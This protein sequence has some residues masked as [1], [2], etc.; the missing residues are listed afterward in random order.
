[1]REAF[2]Q[3]GKAVIRAR[4]WEND[5]RGLADSLTLGSNFYAQIT[6]QMAEKMAANLGSE[7]GSLET[8]VEHHYR[9]GLF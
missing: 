2:F 1:M 8:I 4:L 9:N 6:A 3:C 5:P 7:L